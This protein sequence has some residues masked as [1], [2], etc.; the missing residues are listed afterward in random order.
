MHNESKDRKTEL[1]SPFFHLKRQLKKHVW[2][3]KSS[4]LAPS[5]ISDAMKY[6]SDVWIFHF[7]ITGFS[8]NHLDKL[9]DDKGV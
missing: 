8:C 6:N 9:F 1:D 3:N 4:V 5:D 2:H 7:N